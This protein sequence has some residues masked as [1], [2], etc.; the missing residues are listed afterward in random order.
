MSIYV[1]PVSKA[2][3]FLKDK[4][5]IINSDESESIAMACGEYLAT[6]KKS[7]VVMGE[8]GLLN[9]LDSILTLQKLYQIPIDIKI[10]VRADEPQHKVVSRGLK[11]LLTLYK[12]KAELL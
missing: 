8:N 11:K 12:I 1:V 9:A 4:E 5:Y 6:G 2:K 3:E 10:F 7:T